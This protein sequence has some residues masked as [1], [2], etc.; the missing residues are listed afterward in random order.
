MI[1]EGNTRGYGAEL[2]RHLLNLRDNDHV[3]LHVLNGFV[4]D[5][6]FGA[7]AEAEAISRATQCQKY[8][9]SLSLNPPPGA[10]VTVQQFEEAAARIGLTLGLDGQPHAMVFHEKE[11]RRHAHVVW[12]R[13]DGARLKAINLPHYKRKLATLSQELYRDFGWETPKGFRDKERRDR[14]RYSRAEGQQAKRNHQDAGKLKAMF[15][16]CW[17]GSD[18]LEGFAAALTEQGYFLARGDRRGF[19]AVDADGKIW[20]ISRWCGVKPKELRAKLGSEDALPSIEEVLAGDTELKRPRKKYNSAAFEARRAKLAARQRAEREALRRKQEALRVAELK[21][22]QARLPRGLRALWARATGLYQSL[23]RQIEQEEVAARARDAA[24]RQALIN[25]HL[26]ERQA[27]RRRARSHGL[28]DAFSWS[29]PDQPF[30]PPGDDLKLTAAQLRRTPAAILPPLSE[31]QARFDRTD[32]LRALAK[33]I[34]DPRVLAGLADQALK[35]VEAV[36]LPSDAST[37]YYTTRDYLAAEQ[38]LDQTAASVANTRG[39][40]VAKAHRIAAIDTQNTAMRKAF[41]GSLSAEQRAAL[42]HVLGSSQLASIVG[43]AGA[44]KST[45]L[46]TARAAW[47]AQGFKVHGAALAGKAAEELQSASGISSRTLASLEASWTH[48]RNPIGPGEVLV[49]DE[50]GMIGTRQMARIASKMSEIGAKLVLVGD[51]DQLQP[52]EAGIPFAR[53]IDTHGAA[54][55]TEIHRQ[56]SDWQR[57][58]S[59]E[60][61]AGE[62]HRAVARYRI[63]GAVQDSWDHEEAIDALAERYAADALEN[64]PKTQLAFAHRRR[65]VHALNQAI[66]ARLREDR[67][68]DAETLVQTR[69]GP[70]AFAAGDRIVFTRNDAEI[71]VKN[72]MLGTVVEAEPDVFVVEMD[73]DAPR[74]VRFDPRAFSQVDHGYAVTIHKSQGAT[75]DRSYVLASRSLDRHLAYVALTRHREDMQLYLNT[76]DRP[77]WVQGRDRELPHRARD[78]PSMG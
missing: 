16:A 41:G 54:R 21:A 57:Q 61:A 9:F 1:L 5:D 49:V 13:I 65:D 7:F 3:E 74:R 18:S 51:P 33:Y 32:V 78:G 24:E 39:P 63:Q 31:K 12:S 23:L 4:A 44:G 15:R 2:A 19:V 68:P 34:D 64:P 53:L 56:K 25:G 8:L 40:A 66:R 58:A 69:N 37:R 73:G 75:V 46:D 38:A 62:M 77:A 10:E 76:R 14:T 67:G 52:I 36:S 70:R 47:E 28:R 17:E 43:L 42:D 6:L 48:G 50:A 22:R 55:L 29:D 72:G 30:I 11:G 26:A 45:L 20:S 27:L 35:S 60:L 59:K 71:G